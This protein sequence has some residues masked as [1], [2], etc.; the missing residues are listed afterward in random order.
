LKSR[1]TGL[2]K[3]L[4]FLGIGVLITWLSLRNLTSNDKAD[5]LVSFREVRYFWVII[6]VLIGIFSHIFRA[7]RW[8]MLL[9]PVGTRPTLKHTFIA[10]MV[11]YF[12][13]MAFPRLGEVTR[14]GVLHT[15]DK[16][17]VNKSLGTVITERGLDLIIFLLL[18]VLLIVTQYS[19]LV[20]YLDSYVFPGFASKFSAIGSNWVLGIGIMLFGA[21]I[22]VGYLGIRRARPEHRARYRVKQLVQGFWLGLISIR[23]IKRPWLFVFYSLMIWFCYFLMTWLCFNALAETEGLSAGAGL[24][25]LV[26]GAVGIMITP[27]GIGLYPLIAR[28]TLLLYGI[29]TGTGFAMGWILWTSQTAMIILAGIAALIWL[30]TLKRKNRMEQMRSEE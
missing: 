8:Q 5:L 27:G 29:G 30:S 1:L 10:V 18:F 9:E 13:N 21:L 2:A 17:P 11:G 24:A 20:N 7:L 16:I 3:F 15:T 26:L 25:I 4:L 23:K 14:C 19:Q 28:D 6:V 12:A 22:W